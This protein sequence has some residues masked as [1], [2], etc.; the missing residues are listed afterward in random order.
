MDLQAFNSLRPG[1]LVEVIKSGKT[2]TVR[3]VETLEQARAKRA[4][5]LADP[6]TARH[7]VNDQAY[8]EWILKAFPQGRNSVD[9]RQLRANSK[10]QVVP[11]GPSFVSLKPES[12]TRR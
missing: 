9:F 2:Y 12:I 11:Y 4:A 7:Q 3:T 6:E 8:E 1:E 10:G 5:R